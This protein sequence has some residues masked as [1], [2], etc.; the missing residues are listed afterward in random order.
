MNFCLEYNDLYN[1]FKNKNL[2]KKLGKLSKKYKNKKVLIY[3]A[4]L[5]ANVI[6]EKFDI[7]DFNIIGF[8]D[9]KYPE[10]NYYGY[11]I[12]RP[13]EIKF[14]NADII[15]IFTIN[16]K[17]IEDYLKNFESEVNKIPVQPLIKPNFIDK[18]V[19]GKLCWKQT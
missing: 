13:D 9:L 7:S 14:T 16:Y 5:F 3:G 17:Q 10:N 12:Y 15:L 4:G 11:K 6:L 1:W 19:L 2:Q 18:L 8:V